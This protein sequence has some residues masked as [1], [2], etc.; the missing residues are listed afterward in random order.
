MGDKKY[1][2]WVLSLIDGEDAHSRQYRKLLNYLNRLPFIPIYE[3]DKNRESDGLNLRRRFIYEFRLPDDFLSDLDAKRPKASILEIM[4]ALS[5]RCEEQIMADDYYGN[6]LPRWFW[7]MI[8]SLGLYGQI[9]S[10]FDKTYVSCIIDR[11]INHEYERNGN[12]GLFTIHSNRHDMRKAEIW[13][14]LMWWL[15]ELEG[16]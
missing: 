16:E 9:D 3:M 6:R 15:N 10:E 14:Q 7:S 4:V 1:Y 12:G 8:D 2:E 13:A 5:L 11:F